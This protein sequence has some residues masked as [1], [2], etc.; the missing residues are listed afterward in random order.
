MQGLVEGLTEKQVA[1]RLGLSA[2]TVHT[3]IRRLY[4]QLRVNS[5]S[6]LIGAPAGGAVIKER[7]ARIVGANSIRPSSS[8][9]SEARATHPT[10]L[11]AMNDAQVLYEAIGNGLGGAA[12]GQLFGKPCYKR[13]GKAFVCFFQQ[14]MVFK[15]PG[16]AHTAALSL[17]GARLFDPSGKG[18]PMKEWVQVP[19]AYHEHWAGFAEA[20]WEYGGSV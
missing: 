9:H 15:L 1:H 20:A 4:D 7:G 8:Q 10:Q 13:N 12:A 5:R 14:Q 17:D 6:E 18:R 19:Y 11:A 2:P 3:C 16:E